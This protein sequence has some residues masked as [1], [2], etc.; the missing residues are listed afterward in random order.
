MII[1]GIGYLSYLYTY[2]DVTYIGGGFGVGIH[3]LLEAAT[4]GKPVIFGP[5]HDKFKEAI[6]L[7]SNGG[8]FVISGADDLIHTCELLFSDQLKRTASGDAAKTYVLENAGATEKV[9]D[10]AN[11]YLMV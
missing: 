10:K 9:M 8:G 4:Y 2:A 6:E 7:K 5:N 11:E 1:D 3:N